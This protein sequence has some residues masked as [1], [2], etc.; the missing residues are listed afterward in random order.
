MIGWGWRE[1]RKWKERVKKRPGKEEGLSIK[2][3]TQKEF[4]RNE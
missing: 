4:Q 2:L 3:V 1:K